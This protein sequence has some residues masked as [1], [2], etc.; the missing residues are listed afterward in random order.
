MIKIKIKNN[1]DLLVDSEEKEET[2]RERKDRL[3]PGY[4]ELKQLSLGIMEEEQEE[5]E[6]KKKK[7]KHCSKGNAWHDKKTGKLTSKDKAGS[8]SLQWKSKGKK[9]CKGGV[10]RVDKG[11]ERFVSLPCG[12]ENEDGGK[13]PNKCG[14]KKKK[15]NEEIKDYDRCRLTDLDKKYSTDKK[16]NKRKVDITKE[17]E[18]DYKPI[19]LDQKTREKWQKIAQIQ[20]DASEKDFVKVKSSYVDRFIDW[21]DDQYSTSTNKEKP[22][23]HKRKK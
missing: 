5:L 15:T 22:P 17:L 3:F 10:A 16:T 1:K 2:D 6:E 23:K 11:Q 9:D 19:K 21:L 20:A 14:T 13:A 4:D 12:R 8:F 18:C 7:K